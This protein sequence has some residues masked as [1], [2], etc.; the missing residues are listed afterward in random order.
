VPR[1]SIPER[2]PSDALFPEP[3]NTRGRYARVVL[4]TG[5]DRPEGLTYA[6]PPDLADLAPGERVAA[7]LG[8]GNRSV[9][10]FVV[11]IVTDPGI[12]ASRIKPVRRRTG[13]RL[14]AQL[15]ELARWISVYECC[16][17]GMV[18]AT[19][20]PAA[21]KKGTGRVVRRLIEPTGALPARKLPPKTAQAWDALA[22]V[23]PDV[24]PA[25]PKALVARLELPS[26]APLSRLI[27]LGLLR[28]V[29]REDVRASWREH[30]TP[31]D[32]S[33]TLTDDQ[34]NAVHAITAALG[35]FQPFLLHGVTGSG[36]TEVYLRAIQDVL[37]EGRCAIVLV[38]EISLTPQ[39]AGRF[40]GRFGADQVAVLHSGLTAS[41]RHAQWRRVS[42]GQARVVV[43][44]RSAIF[45]PFGDAQ[46]P[47]GL[48][49]VDEEHDGSYKQDQAPRYH[50]RNVALRRGQIEGCPVVLG[51][52]TPSLESWWNAR[53]G[54]F[55]LLD[56]PSRVGGG[57]L[58][59]VEI[60]DL[61]E[62]RRQRPTER[63]KLHAI[64]LRL[65]HALRQT[66]DEGGQAILMLNRRGYANYIHCPSSGWV[67]Q[68]SE[69][70]VTMV[71]HRA[72]VRGSS[73]P[74]GGVVRCHHCL[75]EQTLPKVC[76]E[77][78]GKLSLFG[79]GT[80]R[81][82]DEL[83]RKFDVLEEGRT[84]LRLDSDTMRKASDYF[85][86]LERFGRGE[87]R[88]LMGTQMIAKGLDFPDVRLI[89][90]VNADTAINLPD[91][92][93]AERTFQLI[94]QVAGR[95]GR[96][97][98][99]RGARVIVQT[100]NPGDLAINAAAAHDY[101]RFA[102]H[103]M[104]MR[105]RANLPPVTRLARIV[106]RDEEHAKAERAA[107][108]AFAFLREH[109]RDVRVRPPAPC[110]ISRIGGRH[111]IAVD[112][113]ARTPGPIQAALAALRSA[114]MVK[115]DHHTMVDVDPVTLL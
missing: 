44:A 43:G 98:A 54:R 89:G 31:Q 68:C 55:A 113:L 16:P 115:A 1:S 61:L 38:P 19:M 84:L 86:A 76:P 29:E 63:D 105:E 72:Q 11:E 94:A 26:R 9:E 4:E 59:R 78:G 48:I 37:R 57:V 56:L 62:E 80:Q 41:Q 92:R 12:D 39:T 74:G 35:T 20:L 24:F 102:N 36:K 8:G 112:L 7:P 106:F 5:I 52:A 100:Y 69:C 53:Q 32:V 109:G 64:G 49:I 97:A 81:L 30:A 114:G 18:L 103:E 22:R 23:P 83:C 70:D 47:L 3:R 91:F 66:L 15:I 85:H 46:T 108:D 82:E 58:P 10:G 28:M 111:R 93:S 13:Q 95:A 65:E 27:S 87:V 21:V 40:I 14:P 33:L 79:F 2:T 75:S 99:S 6:I 110:A 42:Q 25:D 45:A 67:M 101:V 60:V 88:V 73:L 107:H 17:I 51:S 104:E 71:F 90:V 77:S 34:R 96:S 50:A